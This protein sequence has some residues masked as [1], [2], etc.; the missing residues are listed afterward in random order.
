MKATSNNVMKG[1]F[2]SAVASAVWG[3]SGTTVQFISQNQ[4]L[5]A[6]WYLSIRTMGAG[7]ILLIISLFMYG[8]KTFGVFSIMEN[9]WIFISLCNFWF[10][11]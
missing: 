6:D 8:K 1:I 7:V 2:W 10:D 9:I 4:N 3:I 5:P 11:G